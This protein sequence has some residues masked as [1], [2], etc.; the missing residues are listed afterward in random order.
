MNKAEKQSN[1]KKA[2]F[3]KQRERC[4]EI[5]IT[6][7]SESN[8]YRELKVESNSG[9][10]ND[11][12]GKYLSTLNSNNSPVNDTNAINGN[13][14]TLSPSPKIA[15]RGNMIKSTMRIKLVREDN[16]KFTRSTYLYIY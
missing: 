15:N 4:L 7:D 6:D 13:N 5:T 9:R 1:L 3:L 10:G 14:S 11:K 12:E 2:N 8:E 16:P